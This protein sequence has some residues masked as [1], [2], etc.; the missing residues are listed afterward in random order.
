M[1]EEHKASA[2]KTL[3]GAC[4]KLTPQVWYQH[5]VTAASHFWAERSVRIR[6]EDIYGPNANHAYEMTLEDYETVSKIS[7]RFYIAVELPLHYLELSF[8][9]SGCPRLGEE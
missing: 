7:M 5:K 3:L 9:F 6:K 2:D 4:E 8:V 1:A